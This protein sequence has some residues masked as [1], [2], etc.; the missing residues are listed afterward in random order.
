MGLFRKDA[1]SICLEDKTSDELKKQAY[2]DKIAR[3]ALPKNIDSCIDIGNRWYQ[4]TISDD[5]NIYM[6]RI[7]PMS[8]ATGWGEE[9]ERS[10]VLTDTV[11]VGK[12]LIHETI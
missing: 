10:Y 4:W 8:V 1:R 12:R 11:V 5:S 7:C 6:S 9:G 3:S 2:K